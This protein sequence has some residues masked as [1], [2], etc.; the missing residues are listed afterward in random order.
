MFKIRI[1]PYRELP[2]EVKK[3][4]YGDSY[5]SYI[6]IYHNDKLIFCKH[7]VMEPEDVKFSRDLSWVPEIIEKVYKLGLKDGNSLEYL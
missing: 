2:D 6:L 5:G 3:H 1:L 7:D 4:T